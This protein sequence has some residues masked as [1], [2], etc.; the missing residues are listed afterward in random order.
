MDKKKILLKANSL[1][2]KDK[3]DEAKLLISDLINKYPTDNGLYVDAVNIYLE[4]GLYGDAKY[5]FK[6]YNEE[7]GN[8]LKNVDFTLEEIEQEELQD[9]Q[10]RS[11]CEKSNKLSFKR[12][13]FVERGYFSNYRTL[14][15]VSELIIDNDSLTIRKSWRT[16]IYKWQDIASAIIEKRLLPPVK[17]GSRH[18]RRMILKT[19]DNNTFIFDV[20]KV[21]PDF[22]HSDTLISV[23]KKHVMITETKEKKVLPIFDII[24]CAAILIIC[25]AI[26]FFTKGTKG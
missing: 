5:L 12:M 1:I 9:K 6:K 10:K 18:E 3:Y 4:G 22:K 14:L 21:H 19:N 8:N 25:F 16:F 13:S 15:P 2:R 24:L 11:E 17:F 26:L 7:T 20:S 23:F